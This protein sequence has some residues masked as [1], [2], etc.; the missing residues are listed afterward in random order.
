MGGP[1]ALVLGEGV[2]DAPQ[3]PLSAPV[4]NTEPALTS[5]L[6]GLF[7]EL[8]FS[9]SYGGS[10][11]PWVGFLA[12]LC[13]VPNSNR[14]LWSRGAQRARA[15]GP[16]D[17]PWLIPQPCP[18]RQGLLWEWEPWIQDPA[19]RHCAAPPACPTTL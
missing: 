17:I 14:A 6:R 7:S 5:R 1:L 16:G 12:R 8:N 10:S 18:R 19:L 4:L 9:V 11:S 13:T 2:N 15:G 3:F